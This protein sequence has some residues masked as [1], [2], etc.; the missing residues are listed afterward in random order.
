MIRTWYSSAT[1]DVLVAIPPAKAARLLNW[2]TTEKA[3]RIL[4]P[5]ALALLVELRATMPTVPPNVR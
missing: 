5:V 4:D 3:T 1:N 2:L